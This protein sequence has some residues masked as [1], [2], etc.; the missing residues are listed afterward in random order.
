[1]LSLKGLQGRVKLP[2]GGD[3]LDKSASASWWGV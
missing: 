1:M 2:T 3:S